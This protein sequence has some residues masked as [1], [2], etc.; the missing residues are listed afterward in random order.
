MPSNH[1][2]LCRPLL[3]LSSVFLSVTGSF[4]IS[5]LFASGG[6]SFSINP[7]NEHSELISF[8]M[9]WLDFF[10]IQGTLKSLLQY[11]SSKAS[12]FQHSAFFMVQTLTSIHDYWTKTIA[13]TIQ[14]FVFIYFKMNTNNKNP[15]ISKTLLLRRRF[16]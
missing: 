14:N 2:I 13:L 12:I 10:A 7:S 9:D 16:K 5:Q 1:L 15:M 8:R 4:P 3:L 6:F 11:H